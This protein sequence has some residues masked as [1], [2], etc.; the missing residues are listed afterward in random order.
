MWRDRLSR[1]DVVVNYLG[2]LQR[3][4]GDLGCGGLNLNQVRD[5]YSKRWAEALSL[6]PA[7]VDLDAATARHMEQAL[8]AETGRLLP[9]TAAD[10]MEWLALKPGESVEVALRLA[11]VLYS[12][13]PAMDRSSLLESLVE[14]WDQ[15][16]GE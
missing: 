1:T 7:S 11:Q 3:A 4:A 16:Q 12:L 10:V 2:E 5:R 8:L 13:K 9:V 14:N 6:I 15:L